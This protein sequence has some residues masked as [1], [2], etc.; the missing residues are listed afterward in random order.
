MYML[1][2]KE[3]AEIKD[4]EPHTVHYWTKNGLRFQWFGKNKVFRIQDV[5]DFLKT[6]NSRNRK[7]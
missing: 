2:T 3:V 7:K 4:V 5:E 6:W 1:T